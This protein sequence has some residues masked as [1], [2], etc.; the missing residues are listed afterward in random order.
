MSTKINRATYGPS[1]TEV[2]LGALISLL[3]GVV[4]GAGLLVLRPAIVA[5]ST[6]KEGERVRGAVYYIE[7]SRDS[8]KA[9]EAQQKLKAFAGGQ[10]VTVVEDE[11][12]ALANAKAGGPAAPGAGGEKGKTT[13]KGKAPAKGKEVAKAAPPAVAGEMFA[14]GAPNFRIHEGALQVAVPVT[15][16]VNVLDL[17]LKFI[18]QARGGIT[19]KG[20]AFAFD[21]TELYLGSCPV[22]RLPFLAGYVSEYLFAVQSLPDDVRGSWAKLAGVTI[23]GSKLKLTMP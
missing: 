19:K 3:L 18:A 5:K 22:Q 14:I 11:L 2:I 1:W 13:D 15:V 9:K 21:A 10:S 6:P 4:L 20:S 23:E 7:G 16:T 17:G 12:N 8:A